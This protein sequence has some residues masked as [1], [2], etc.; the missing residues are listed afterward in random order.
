VPAREAPRPGRRLPCNRPFRDGWS[1]FLGGDRVALQAANGQ[2][3]V[4]EG[5]GGRSG[6]GSVNANRGA[7]GA[8]ETFVITVH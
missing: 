4:A 5:G 8:W 2:Y 1:D 6:S 3:V 7:V